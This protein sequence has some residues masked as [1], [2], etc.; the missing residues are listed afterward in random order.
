[1]AAAGVGETESRTLME[2][3]PTCANCHSFSLDGKTMGLDVDGP[4]ND[5]ACTRWCQ[6]RKKRPSATKM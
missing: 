3:L 5:K 4:Q 1:M 2:N 6:S